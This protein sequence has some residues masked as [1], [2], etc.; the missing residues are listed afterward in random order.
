[1]ATA[2]MEGKFVASA[3]T[4]PMSSN[5][6]SFDLNGDGHNDNRLGNIIGALIMNMLDVQGGINTSIMSGSVLLLMDLKASDLTNNDCAEADISRGTLMGTAMPK[7][8]GTDMFGVDTSF[9]TGVTK[10]KITGG[11]FISNNPATAKTDYSMSVQFPLVTGEPPLSLTIHGAHIQF[12]KTA[13]GIMNGQINGGIK[14]EDV[15]GSI[16]PTV[17][18]LLTHRLSMGMGMGL[19]GHGH[20]PELDHLVAVRHRRLG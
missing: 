17:A 12:T 16:I 2:G 15:Q 9:G 6:F 4:A 10:G 20:G 8:D 7:Y 14:S 3:I 11:K 19:D 1:M 13:T 18:A 5:D